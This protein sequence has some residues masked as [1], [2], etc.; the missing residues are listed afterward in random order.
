MKK[1]MITFLSLN[2]LLRLHRLGWIY[3]FVNLS[4]SKKEILTLF[5]FPLLLC[6]SSKA[7]P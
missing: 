7:R 4:L 6:D 1:K 5:F 2:P 3:F